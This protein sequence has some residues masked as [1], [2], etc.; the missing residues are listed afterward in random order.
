MSDIFD[1]V[2][3]DLRR[4][5]LTNLWKRYG[6]VVYA[7]AGLIVAGTAA[8]RGYDYWATSRANAAGD[9][10]SQVLASA[11]AGDHKALAESL[12]LYAGSAPS[13]YQVLAR[14]RAASEHAALGETDNALAAFEDLSKA[15]G[16]DVAFL[17]LATIRA[18]LIAVDRENLD[19]I[20]ARVSGYNN[21]IS[22][23]RHA[24]R[25]IIALASVRA[26]DWK[27]VSVEAR[28]LTDDPATPSDVRARARILRDLAISESGNVDTGAAG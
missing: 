15:P 21:D 23:W 6:W 13:Q 17:D 3:D 4:D 9:A 28:K 14:F 5:R 8:W 22:P 26:E 2:G 12:S 1:E 24:A 20:K 18:A 19:Q 7:A 10:Y 11:K 16:V 27:G 25:E